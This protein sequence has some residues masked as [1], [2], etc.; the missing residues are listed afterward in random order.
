[1]ELMVLHWE[2][3]KQKLS[4]KPLTI[5]GNGKQKRD[6]VNAKDVAIAFNK[7]IYVKKNQILNIGSSK[8]ITVN[9]L[10]SL[11][12]SKKDKNTKKTW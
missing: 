3:L 9:Y 12:S 1:M 6:F 7:A 11:I 2:F 10:A 8:P 4:N 5:V